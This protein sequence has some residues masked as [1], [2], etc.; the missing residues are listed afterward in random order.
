MASS[1]DGIIEAADYNDIR[2][3][4]IRVLGTGDGNFGYGQSANL[5]SVSVATGTTVS[6]AQ[7]QGLRWDIFNA[8][9]HQIGTSPTIGTVATGD[10]IRFGATFPNNAYDTLANTLTT[11]RFNLGEGRSDAFVLGS[12]TETFTWKQ[13]TYIDITHTF[14][15]SNAAR[16]FFNSGGLL[17]ITS[18]FSGTDTSNQQNNAWVAL[19]ADVGTQGFG[20]QEPVTGFTPLTG[21]NFYRLTNVFQDYHTSTSSFP[22][23]SNTYKLQAKC[24]VPTNASGSA[25]IVTIRVL[26]TDGYID[27][28]VI[29]GFPETFRGTIDQVDGTLTVETGIRLPKGIM[30]KPPGVAD[31]TIV[32]P[33]TDIASAV[34]IRT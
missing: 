2:N 27:P 9:T 29:A 6:A 8:L 24:N 10:I 33:T 17:R 20:G 16:F 4:V 34:F 3:K 23:S 15:D 11:N 25:N 14:S 1:V 19:L 30:Q 21:E 13:F 22:Y 28:D 26:F 12:K 7:W 32:G 5:N 18:Y 31:F